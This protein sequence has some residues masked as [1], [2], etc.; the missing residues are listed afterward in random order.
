MYM[1]I[2]DPPP[3]SLIK[4]YLKQ[5]ISSGSSDVPSI[6]ENYNYKRLRIAFT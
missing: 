1:S 5:A 2:L 4:I 3:L 6:N